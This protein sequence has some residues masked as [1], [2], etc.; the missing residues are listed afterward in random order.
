[1]DKI[2]KTVAYILFLLMVSSPAWYLGY[3][4]YQRS[5]PHHKVKECF[6]N[7]THHG[8]EFEPESFHYEI[9]TVVGKQRY[10]YTDVLPV[11]P[12]KWSP[13]QWRI[14]RD[15]NTLFWYFDDDSDRTQIDC[16]IIKKIT[17][18]EIARL[19]KIRDQEQR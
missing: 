10:K 19:E 2:K 18:D 15:N 7:V 14:D 1:M 9:I 4:W 16:A 8:N 13:A 17:T 3:A 12:T 11:E 6:K 5:V